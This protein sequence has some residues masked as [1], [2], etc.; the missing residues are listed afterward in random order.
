MKTL[1][2]ILLL[3]ISCQIEQTAQELPEKK[4][5]V[6][7]L[8]ERADKEIKDIRIRKLEQRQQID[9]LKQELKKLK[10]RRR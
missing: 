9:S 3:M 5:K 2:P 7:S 6:D 10:R 4:C 1:L 8:I